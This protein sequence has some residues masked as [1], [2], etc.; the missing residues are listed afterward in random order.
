M[1]PDVKRQ[2]TIYHSSRKQRRSEP[3]VGGWFFCF[4]KGAADFVTAT[5]KAE[6][7]PAFR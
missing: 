4:L 7:F 5:K 6:N 3:V 1:A 2:L